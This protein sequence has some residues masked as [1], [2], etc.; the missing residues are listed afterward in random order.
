MLG[1][2]FE[3]VVPA[4]QIAVAVTLDKFAQPVLVFPGGG[5]SAHGVQHRARQL[6]QGN[7]H[8]GA[9]YDERAFAVG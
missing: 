7:A 5:K 1:Q 3:A 2:T 4:G 6:P 8:G 9:L